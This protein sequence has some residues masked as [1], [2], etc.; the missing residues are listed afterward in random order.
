MYGFTTT[1]YSS[2]G[3]GIALAYKAGLPLKDMEFV[4]FHP[5]GLIPTG[6]LITE[7]VRGEGGYLL[8]A[9][10]RRFMEDYAKANG[11]SLPRA[12]SSRAP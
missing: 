12:T 5:T 9:E 3:D 7:A 2:T 4:Q 1:A 11:W 8:N 6:V 10:N